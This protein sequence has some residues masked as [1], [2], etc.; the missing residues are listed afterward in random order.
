MR[1][2]HLRL[3]NRYK[4]LKRFFHLGKK[5]SPIRFKITQNEALGLQI[6]PS[7][8]SLFEQVFNFTILPKF[9]SQNIEKKKVSDSN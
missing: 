3:S 5:L 2:R 9:S 7:S 8:Y 6:Y 4:A 1:C